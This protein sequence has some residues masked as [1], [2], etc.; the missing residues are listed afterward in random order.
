MRML[1]IGLGSM[2]KRRI[3]NLQTLGVK[4]IGGV[5]PREDRREESAS[6][7][8]VPTFSSVE[9]AVAAFAPSALV[10]ATP[11]DRH[12][13]YAFF[14]YRHRL[15]CFIEASVVDAD[16]ILELHNL[17]REGGPIMAPS[18]TM[19]YFPGPAKVKELIRAG[20]IGKVLNINY[21]TGQYLKDWHPWEPIESYYVSKRLTG[22]C[23]EIVPFEL[24]WLNDVFGEPKPLACLRDRVGDMSVD[25]DDIYHFW[26]RY[27]GGTLANITIEVLSRPEVTREMRVLG[28]MGQVVFSATENVV[29]MRTLG[30]DAWTQFELHRGRAE[31]GYINA[32]EPYV[33]ELCDFLQAVETNNPAA[34]PNT[35]LNDYAVLQT[36]C[37]L[38]R[39]AV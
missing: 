35:L 4:N 15:P 9:E 18:C 25:I 22:G 1:V 31:D 13:D 14:G 32:E 5:D 12:M 19:R 20:A 28:T 26:L 34:F 33:G 17:I 23:R 39:L 6:K 36:L 37:A 24:T 21:H 3:R 2:G 7:F 29:R 38:E 10:I 30:S 8:A 16:K 27:P 11:P